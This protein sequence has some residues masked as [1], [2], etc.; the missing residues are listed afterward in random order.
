MGFFRGGFLGDFLRLMKG[1]REVV[2]RDR[3]YR[4]DFFEV[5]SGKGVLNR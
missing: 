1:Y 5:R 4:I 2:T 3:F